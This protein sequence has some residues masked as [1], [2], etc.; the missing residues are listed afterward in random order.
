MDYRTQKQIIVA[1]LTLIAVS[2]FSW[3]ILELFNIG[4]PD[5]PLP[6]Q[7][8]GANNGEGPKLKALESI[9]NEL[10]EVKPG[11]Y[12]A[13]AYIQNPNPEYGASK[14]E[15]EFIFEDEGGRELY[16][17]GGKT[18][19]LPEQSR[20]IIDSAIS[21]DSTPYSIIFRIKSVGW[22]RLH[23]FS[24]L[25]LSIADTELL[26]DEASGITRFLGVVKNRSPYNLQNIE[27]QVVLFDSEG[28]VIAAGETNIQTLL[29]GTDRFFQIIWPYTLPLNLDIDERVESNFLENSNF[30]REYGTPQKFQEYY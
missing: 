15:Y 20:Y 19:I 13:V 7:T 27:A 1:L 18:F 11:I 30:I 29:R 26:R 12:D 25:G 9:F 5:E 3:G 22:E 23:P 14:I 24:S 8:T 21:L 16:R 28:S 4:K 17:D 10:L 2:V 6:P